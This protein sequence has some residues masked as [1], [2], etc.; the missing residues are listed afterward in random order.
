MAK[1]SSKNEVEARL[2]EFK[3]QE[4][5]CCEKIRGLEFSVESKNNIIERLTKELEELKKEKEGLDTKL[6]V[7]FPPPA[8]VYSPSKKDM[9]WTGLSEFADDTITDYSRPSSTIESNSDDLQNRDSFVIETGESSSTILYKPVIKFV[10]VA[11]R[12]TEIKTNKVETMKK[13]AAKYAEMYIKTSKSSNRVKRL[14]RELKA[15]TPPIKIHKIDRGRSRSVMAW[16]PKKAAATLFE[17]ELIKILIDKMEK[18][19]SFDVADYKREFYDALVK[20]YNTD[21]D[22]FESYGEVFSLKGSQDDKDKDQDPFVGSDRGTKRRK[23]SKDVVSSRDSRSKEKKSSSTSQDAS[24]SQHKYS[25]KS[26]HAKEPSHAAE[27]SGMQQDQEFITRDNDEQPINKEVTKADW[28]K[29][30]KRPPTPDPNWKVTE[31]QAGNVQTSLTLSSAELEIQSMVDVPIHQEDPAVQRTPLINTI[32]SM[33]DPHGFEGYPNQTQANDKAIFIIA[34]CFVSGIYKHGH[35][36]LGLQNV[37]IK[38]LLC[39]VEVTAAG[40]GY[41]CCQ[42]SDKS[43]AGLGYKELIPEIFVNLSELLEKHDNRSDKGYHEVS[44]PLRGNYMPPKRD[45][46]LIDEHFVSEFVDVSN[47]SSSAVMTVETIDANRKCMFSKEK[48]KPIKK[49]N[50][51]PPIIEDLVSKSKEEEEPKFQKQ[52]QP[53][54]PKIEFVKAKDQNQS[55]RKPVKQV[56]QATSNTHKSRGN[57]WN[58]NNLMNQRLGRNDMYQLIDSYLVRSPWSIKGDHRVNEKQMQTIEEKVDTSKALDANLVDIE[59][60]GPESKERDTNSRSRNDAHADDV[61]IRPI[62]DEEPMVEERG[63]AIAAL[64]NKLRKLTGNSVNTKFAKSSILEKPVLQ[65]HRNQS[66]VRQPTALKSER[67]RISKPR[68]SSQVDVINDLSKPVTTHYL[69]KGKESTCE[70]PHHMIAPGSSRYSSND[71]I[72][73]HYLEEAKKKTQKSSRNSEPSVMPSARLQSTANNSKPKPRINNQNP[74]T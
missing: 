7:L 8:Q 49:N 63:F 44:P 50:F 23:S 53:S 33:V 12:P 58:W 54:F 66:V 24:Q 68:F 16:V 34:N 43:K 35:R 32:V 19:K 22:I 4:I 38:K 29:K 37:G 18:N 59:S 57:Q 47:V 3:N 45:L 39:A 65:P 41:Y 56:E 73:N 55:F 9:S 21:K 36:V 40:Y 48:A 11:D 72:H 13:P 1:S 30:P 28:F 20:S 70:K 14:E 64:K 27:Y 31:K 46:R 26:A 10:K 15:R 61:D 60:S 71:M 17:F 52:V 2:V 51:S 6:T 42:V 5:K 25:S 69:P 67:P 74:R 62:I